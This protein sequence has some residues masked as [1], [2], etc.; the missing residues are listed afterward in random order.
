MLLDILGIVLPV[1]ATIVAAFIAKRQASR[2]L[3]LKFDHLQK[4]WEHEREL[5]TESRFSEMAAAVSNY[6]HSQG[7]NVWTDAL[8]KVAAVRVESNG[9]LAA[10]LDR[11]YDVLDKGSRDKVASA[12]SSAINLYRDENHQ[13]APE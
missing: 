6:I 10:A 5:A 8:A 7:S 13:K 3:E 9:D 4:Q 11:L 2:E 1:L 12:L